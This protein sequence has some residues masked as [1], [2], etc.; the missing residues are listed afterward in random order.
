MKSNQARAPQATA[1]RSAAPMPPAPSVPI[2]VYRELAAEL[3]ATRAMIDA[4]NGKNQQLEREH[5]QIL[6]EMQRLAFSLQ[7]WIQNQPSFIPGQ[8]GSAAT[9][10]T[11]Q[12]TATA[13]AVAASL[14]PNEPQPDW[15]AEQPVLS[16]ATTQAPTGRMNSLWLILTVIAIILTAFGAGFLIMRP[17]LP[18]GSK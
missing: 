11:W 8:T 12:E 9:H 2:S 14:R 1:G 6:Q 4:L 16:Q 13:T 10:P 18:T 3:Q 5:Q 17:F 7:P 15:V